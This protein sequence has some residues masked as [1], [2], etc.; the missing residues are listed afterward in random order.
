MKAL[1]AKNYILIFLTLITACAFCLGFIFRNDQSVK[2]AEAQIEVKDV[3]LLGETINVGDAQINYN[4]KTYSSTD[5]V[6]VCPNGEAYSKGEYRKAEE[7][8]S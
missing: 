3:Y 4:Q 2:A 7:K 5:G 1:K 8:V 6:L